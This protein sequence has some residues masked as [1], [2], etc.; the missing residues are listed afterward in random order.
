[1]YYKISHFLALIVLNKKCLINTFRTFNGG[2]GVTPGI[3][4]I[5][6]ILFLYYFFRRIL[7]QSE[8]FISSNYFPL[9]AFEF[10]AKSKSYTFINSDCSDIPPIA[11]VN[12]SM[13]DS[14]KNEIA[15]S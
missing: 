12:F 11:R 1:M 5:T 7:F 9:K 15:N 14:Q 6:K 3:K 4:F 10:S 2:A 13:S 8:F